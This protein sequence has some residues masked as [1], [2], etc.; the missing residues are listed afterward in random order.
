MSG[1]QAGGRMIRVAALAFHNHGTSQAPKCVYDGFNCWRRRKS[2]PRAGLCW[3][4]DCAIDGRDGP[5]G[6]SRV[7]ATMCLA[8]HAGTPTETIEAVVNR[9]FSLIAARLDARA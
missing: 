9:Y 2:E 7:G 4:G 1:L 5:K 8:H 6:P 3:S